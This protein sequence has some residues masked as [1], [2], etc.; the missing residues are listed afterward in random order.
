MEN[1]IDTNETKLYK[2]YPEVLEILLKDRT[3]GGN[4]IWATD[5]YENLGEGYRFKDEITVER[6]TGEH[7]KVIRPRSLKTRDEQTERTKGMAEV[8]TPSWVCNEQNN[9]IDDAWFGQKGVFN[10]MNEDNTW[11]VTEPLLFPKGKT[12]NAYINDVRLEITCGEAPYIVSRYDTTTGIKKPV[13]ER[14]GLLDRKL[15]AINCLTPDD[16]E[17]LTPKMRK[18]LKRAWRR[19]VYH[20]YQSIYGFEWQGDS[21][22]LAREALFESF[23]DYYQAKWKVDKHPKVEALKK[24][25]E[26]ISWNIWQMDGLTHGI[27]GFTPTEKPGEIG[28]MFKPSPRERL[29]RVKSW[30]SMEPLKG[31]EFL[32]TQLL[33]TKRH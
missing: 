17:E 18:T 14:V 7:E 21:L 22:L 3:T 27:P 16:S 25:A 6:I 8:F 31:E 9:L 13:G 2:R 11:T 26:I 15:W 29:C 19:R 4:I 20:A 12:L 10:T 28:G 23:I 33:N 30:S 1:T 32:F 24:V 5:S